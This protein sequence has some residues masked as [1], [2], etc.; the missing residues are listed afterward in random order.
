MSH[1][2][3]SMRIA[4]ILRY[5]LSGERKSV[6]ELAEEFNV[7]VRTLQRDI[8]ERLGFLPL[9]RDER[10][11]YYVYEEALGKLGFKDL[12]EFAR[13]SGIAGLYPS[14]D[15]RFLSDLL[16]G[17]QES[18]LIKNQGFEHNATLRERFQMLSKAVL[19]H[20]QIRFC[21]KDSPRLIHPYRLLNNQGIWYLLG[22]ENG[23][24]KHFALARISELT[25][26]KE[27]FTPSD[28]IKALIESS[29]STWVSGNAKEAVL[30][31]DKQAREY[32]LRKQFIACEMMS[33]ADSEA[34][35]VDSEGF[36]VRCVYSYDDEVLNLT[37]LFLPYVRILRPV[38][39]QERLE[40][41]LKVY[42]GAL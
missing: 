11:R 27:T 41:Q 16:C 19:G 3:M 42:I 14:L 18:L 9:M 8:H 31:V 40:A 15:D 35:G 5:L 21:Y 17:A 10:G 25:L 4:S 26:S 22:D 1:D 13:L 36:L 34:Y 20:Y 6:G 38:G 37:K 32:F 33:E 24:L 12:R 30:R 29:G 28:E 39:L 23:T 2:S 7:S